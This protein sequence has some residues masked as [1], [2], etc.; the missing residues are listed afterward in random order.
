MDLFTTITY[1]FVLLSWHSISLLCVVFIFIFLKM[2]PNFPCDFLLTH[3]LVKSVLFNFHT[4]VN[5]PV[6]LLL[7]NSSFILLW[8]E[9]EIR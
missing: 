5:F 1:L 8:S 4:T 6:F 2:F 7:M 3:R 9:K